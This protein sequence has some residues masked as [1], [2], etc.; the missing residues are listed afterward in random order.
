MKHRV[1]ARQKHCEKRREKRESTN[2]KER[3]R[4]GGREKVGERERG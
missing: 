3:E 4:G 1:R 2:V